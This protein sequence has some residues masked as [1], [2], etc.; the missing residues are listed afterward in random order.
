MLF[1]YTA[2]IQAMGKPLPTNSYIAISQKRRSLVCLR[3]VLF[4]CLITIVSLFITNTIKAQVIVETF[5]ESGAMATYNN[6]FGK[7]TETTRF[8]A[9][10]STNKTIS[11]TGT[12]TA[13]TTS[14]SLTEPSVCNRGGGSTTCETSYSTSSTLSTNSFSAQTFSTLAQNDSTKTTYSWFFG[15]SNTKAANRITL[16]SHSSCGFHSKDFF[17]AIPDESLVITP[18]VPQGISTISFWVMAPAGTPTVEVGFRTLTVA[19]TD[20]TVY[21]T[22]PSSTQEAST[23]FNNVLSAYNNNISLSTYTFSTATSTASYTSET[24]SKNHGSSVGTTASNSGSGIGTDTD[25]LFAQIIF[26]IPQSLQGSSGQIAIM[27]SGGTVN[28]D[29]I[30]VFAAA[31]PGTWTG[32][33]G[34][35]WNDINNWTYLTV[36]TSTTD[37]TIP[38]TT[39]K[40]VLTNSAAV[41]NLDLASG[42]TLDMSGQ[43]FTIN[44]AISGTGKIKTDSTS[45]LIMGGSSTG[46]LLLSTGVG[47]LQ[48]LTL[49]DGA[50]ITL[51]SQ[52]TIISSGTLTVGSVT[53][54]I[55]NTG[56]LL[57]LS[58]YNTGS[59]RVAQVPVNSSGVSL[60]TISGSVNVL[61]Y[62]HSDSSSVSTARRGWRLLT[63]PITNYGLGTS[64]CTIYSGWQNG[65]SY[66]PGQ[67]T[68]ITGP[69][70]VATGPSGNGLDV[71]INANYSM[72][73]WNVTTQ[74]LVAVNSTKVPISNSTGSADNIPY[75]IFIR[76]DRTPNTVNLPW[77]A[78]INNTTLISKGLLQLGN[79]KFSSV[80]TPTMLTGTAGA[81][82][83][84][85]NPYACSIDFS[86]VAGDV[87]G[88]TPAASS[89]LVNI[90][91]RFYMW[92]ANLTGSQGVGEY[93]C[94]D[95][96]AYSGTYAKTVDSLLG[97]SLGNASAA[98][99]SIQSG[100]AIF[101]QT[102]SPNP[103]GK[104]SITFKEATK[105]TTNNF[106]YRPSNDQAAA[107]PIPTFAATLSLLNSDNTTSLTDGIVAQFKDGY[108]NC[109]DNIDAPKFSNADEMFS[110][111]RDG[112]QVCI[113]RRSDIT[114]ADTLFLTLQQMAQR[115]YQFN[116]ATTLANHPGIGAHLEDNYTNTHTPLNMSGRNMVDFTIDS[117]TASQASNR[118]MV[119]FG[120][121][122]ITPAYAYITAQKEGNT[123]PVEWSVSNDSSM[124]TYVLQRS[125][126][127][128]NY[129]TV[130]TTI[131]QHNGNGYSWIDTNPATGTNYYRVLSTD[132][133]NEQSY[134]QV[135]SVGI[136][137]LNVPGITV[138][139]NPIQ[140]QQIGIA[141]NAMATGTYRYIL[142]NDLGQQIQ[143]G[144]FTHPGGNATTSIPINTAISKGTYELEIF[145]PN[146]T[147]STLTVVY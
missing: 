147:S 37:V 141:I 51:G 130:Y 7:T 24:I 105:N 49:D 126:D 140:N 89:G 101:I 3:Y 25:S 103:S 31:E 34:T 53:G 17:L 83:L 109:V 68:M 9:C 85:G 115:S 61:C 52:V 8:T 116:F 18:V 123:I 100:Q 23:I 20:A 6:V 14:N 54:A 111:S 118:F 71:G 107:S 74:K 113:E 82:S 139:P 99:L 79:Q 134:S 57:T 92:D 106:I 47:L 76:G 30:E 102:M 15:A 41:R 26:T 35:D 44:G 33:G 80:T 121:L 63:V 36:P 112:K 94:I 108:C 133:L 87:G 117:N 70:S 12:T 135:V 43:T 114:H 72:Y 120:S 91:N 136:P 38:S 119:V 59:A 86:K 144:S 78:T 22:Y 84:I 132:I 19:S 88:G 4:S 145:D 64:A 143:T 129:T 58:S 48:S 39:N 10:T 67:G 127:G 1:N 29:D 65:D 96:A 50:N 81:L 138:Y 56:G 69:T 95:D 104:D 46:T 40:P 77:L 98:D 5:D 97:T 13:Y 2:K 125:T 62:I 128:I 110:L 27:V 32:N 90:V 124:T 28:I 93:V 11:Y 137:T 131:A 66:V 146:N 142:L 16:S 42:A 45:N 60:S 75:F 122:N 55:L 73:T 21:A